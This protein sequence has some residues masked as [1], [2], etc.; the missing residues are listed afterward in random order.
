MDCGIPFCHNG[1]PLGNLIPEWNDLIAGTRT[2]AR[3]ATPPR[4]QQLPGVHRS[5]VPGAVRDRVRARHQPGPRHHQTGRGRDRRPRLGPGLGRP[6]PAPSVRQDRRRDRVRPEAGRGQQLTR[7]GH[8]VV[9]FER[10]D[11]VGALLRYGIPEFKM[12]KRHGRPT[13]RA[14]AGR[15]REVPHRRRRR[16]RRHRHGPAPPLRRRRGRG[17]RHAPATCRCPAASSPASTRP[18]SSSPAPTGSHRERAT[19]KVAP[20]DVAG[21]HVVIIGGGDRRR[22][23]RHRRTVRA[24]P[25]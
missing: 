6:R 14:D 9:V 3:P 10:D 12:E 5:A 23:P 18:W 8:T 7:A 17:G 19:S 22:L 2:G 16:H 1:C 15:G 25:P 4:D 11:R 24:R 21:K 13:P 20:I